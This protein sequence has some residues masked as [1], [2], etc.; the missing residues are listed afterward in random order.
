MTQK[1]DRQIT[2]FVL[3][4]I[5]L[6]LLLAYFLMTPPTE[7][8]VAEEL[9]LIL[10][11]QIADIEPPEEEKRPDRHRFLGLYDSTV[12]QE[13]VASTPRIPPSRRRIV[14][15]PEG[16]ESHKR[17]GEGVAYPGEA[18]GTGDQKTEGG[19]DLASI[20]PS[21]FFP[22][23][24][25][26]ERTYLNVLR[27]PKIAYFVQLKKRFKLT[28][29][30]IPVMQHYFFANQ[31]VSAQIETTVA[32]QI[33]HDGNLVRAFVVRSS[34]L[35]LFDEEALRAVTAS[36]PFTAPPDDLLKL[37]GRDDGMLDVV[38]TFTVYRS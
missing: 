29:D 15:G 14:T 36:A 38:F 22:N 32:F 12:E 25:I 2:L 34:G 23:I 5:L 37:D 20:L 6:H 7:P 17:E 19:E 35:P 24:R 13:E 33:N 1:S 18:G 11:Q 10:K 26:G 30:P 16:Q 21:E 9:E 4:S 27:Y 3:L 8:K 28:W 31:S